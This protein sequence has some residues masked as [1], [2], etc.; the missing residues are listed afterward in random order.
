MRGRPVAEPLRLLTSRT[1]PTLFGRPTSARPSPS[2][3]C[4]ATRRIAVFFPWRRRPLTDGLLQVRFVLQTPLRVLSKGHTPHSA[5][6]RGGR[7]HA[8]HLPLLVERRCFLLCEPLIRRTSPR[9]PPSSL[10]S[11]PL[12]RLRTAIWLS[13]SYVFLTPA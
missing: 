3:P 8:P 11:L 13:P 5:S 9:G 6:G 12:R 4:D 7:P 1:L 2:S 10:G